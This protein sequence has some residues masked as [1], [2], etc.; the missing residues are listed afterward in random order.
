MHAQHNRRPLSSL[1]LWSVVRLLVVTLLTLV[2]PG[3]GFKLYDSYY[4]SLFRPVVEQS[5]KAK[6]ETLGA[7]LKRHV[8]QLR[9]TENRQVRQSKQSLVSIMTLVMVMMRI[10]MMM[11]MMI[12]IAVFKSKLMMMVVVVE[13]IMMVM[14][15]TML[16]ATVGLHLPK[17]RLPT[18]GDYNDDLMNGGMSNAFLVSGLFRSPKQCR[19]VLVACKQ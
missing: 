18:H 17:W 1:S 9:S 4:N 12:M 10:T 2:G 7:I 11:V 3:Q 19:Q 13:R 8:Q 14:V 16:A 5:F 6:V 15:M